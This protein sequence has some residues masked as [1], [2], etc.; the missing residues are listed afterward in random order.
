METVAHEYH[1]LHGL[2]ELTTDFYIIF[3]KVV[4]IVYQ[5]KIFSR[6]HWNWLFTECVKYNLLHIKCYCLFAQTNDID[7]NIDQF[8]YW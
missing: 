8:A 1:V 6:L 2:Y 3:V 5:I 7:V 4:I